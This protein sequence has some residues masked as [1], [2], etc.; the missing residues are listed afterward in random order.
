MDSLDSHRFLQDFLEDL[1]GS[2]LESLVLDQPLEYEA[3]GRGVPYS[4]EL[5]SHC[6]P[7]QRKFLIYLGILEDE[8]IKETSGVML[9][10]NEKQI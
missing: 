4:V 8:M 3:G 6:Q 10:K 5:L 2:F 9:L 1:A 7:S